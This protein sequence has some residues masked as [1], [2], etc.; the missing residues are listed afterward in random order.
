ME[1]D[2]LKQNW[3]LINKRLQKNEVLNKR[4]IKEMI[5]KRTTSAYNKLLN[6]EIISLIIMIILIPAFLVATQTVKYPPA[7]PWI[8]CLEILA[9]SVTIWIIIKIHWL[10][11]FDIENKDIYQLG[12]IIQI[13]RSWILKE[14]YI[15]IPL[16]MIFL[17]ARFI[18][19]H[20]Q[21]TPQFTTLI[22]SALIFLPVYTF[23]IYYFFYKKHFNNIQK[24]LQELEEFKE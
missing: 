16:C 10:K 19:V 20:A 22:I 23:T 17:I 12:R 1:L 6:M 14:S 4:I 18:V 11:K 24:S 5:T 13:Y 8:T 15:L 9:I 2:D 21:S 7:L 3:E